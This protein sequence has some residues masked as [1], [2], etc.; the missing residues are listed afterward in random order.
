MGTDGEY[1]RQG[2]SSTVILAID[3][4][5]FQGLGI[6]VKKC[7]W[8]NRKKQGM[9]VTVSTCTSDRA[10]FFFLLSLYYWEEGARD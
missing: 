9:L 3:G 5:P 2:P 7:V 1:G 6:I 10:L 8:Y 4:I